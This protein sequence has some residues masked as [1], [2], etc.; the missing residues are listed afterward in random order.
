MVEKLKLPAPSDDVRPS[1]RDPLDE[2]LRAADRKYQVFISSTYADLIEERRAVTEVILSMGHIPVGMELFEAGNED[3]W[4]Y[5]RNR[6]LEV[7]YYLL[8]VAERYGSTGPDGLSYTEM[9]YRYAVEQGVPIA[10]LLLHSKAREN[11]PAAKI[12][13]DRRKKLEAFRKRC[14]ERLVSYWSD[15][16][17]L[18]TKCQLA[19]TGMIRRFPRP[20]WISGDQAVSPQ[21]AMELARLSGE[22]A[23]LREELSAFQ[24]Q[25]AA[26]RELDRAVERFTSPFRIQIE[27]AARRFDDTPIWGEILARPELEPM[28][29]VSFFAMV[30]ELPEEFLD[31]QK[32]EA[33]DRWMLA[34]LK[35]KLPEPMRSEDPLAGDAAARTIGVM[36]LMIRSWGF[37]ETYNVSRPDKN[38][39]LE[40]WIRLSPLGRRAF[41]EAL[42]QY[43]DETRSANG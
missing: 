21:L 19:L 16:G 40:T 5:I 36:T 42:A 15:S 24:G 37:L 9:E 33:S 12:D 2:P 3:Q 32:R 35:Q 1:S 6:I 34:F 18:T 41:D 4:S 14:Q 28:L 26:D 31:G 30:F 43:L 38:E 39:K 13:F 11:W 7:D 22:N 27:R 29:S 17:T 20:G 8:V 10:A 23:R 25:Q